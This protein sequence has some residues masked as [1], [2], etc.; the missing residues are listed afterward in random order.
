MATCAATKMPFRIQED[1][2]I[3]FHYF[4]VDGCLSENLERETLDWFDSAAP[5]QLKETDFYEQYEFSLFDVALP[6]AVAQLVSES[7]LGA[8][9]KAMEKIFSCALDEKIE[10]VAHKLI[11]GQRI[12]IHNDYLPGEETHRL[13][14]QLNRGLSDADGGFFI[15][16]NSFDANDVHRILRPVSGS[17]VGFAISTNSHHAVSRINSGT[18]YTLVYSFHAM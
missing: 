18:R 3:P 5:W 17:G 12:A 16:F 13:T 1:H 11:A 9:R 14:I 2:C 6:S 7:A 8:L 10:L 4:L 15:L